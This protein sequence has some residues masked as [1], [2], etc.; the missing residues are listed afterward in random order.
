[1]KTTNLHGRSTT[2]VG[3][4]GWR[5]T[6]WVGFIPSAGST[7]ETQGPFTRTGGDEGLAVWLRD[8]VP[9]EEPYELLTTIQHGLLLRVFG[10]RRRRGIY[11]QLSYA[12]ALKI[13]GCQCV[14]AMVRQRRLHFAGGVARQSEGRLPKRMVFGSL[15]GKG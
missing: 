2:V 1:M 13:V 9:T 6:V 5:E 3:Q 10:Y 4:R 12:Q 8:V 15:V 7:A 11:R 14:E